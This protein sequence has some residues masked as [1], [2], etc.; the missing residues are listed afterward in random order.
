M[1]L[2]S[3][4]PGCG[5]NRVLIELMGLLVREPLPIVSPN[6]GPLFR[7]IE[8]LRPTILMSEAEALAGNDADA[9]A[10]REILNEGYKR[11]AKVPRC[12]GDDHAVQYFDPYCPK[13]FASIGGL[14]GALLT[15]CI[16]IHMSKR[17]A[18]FPIKGKRQATRERAAKP[19]RERIEAY[20]LQVRQT[21]TRLAEAEPD[22]GYWPDLTN[23][24][25]EVW[26]PLLM[27]ARIAGPQI[28]ERAHAAAC[29][30]AGLNRRIQAQ[31]SRLAKGREVVD[32]L[33]EATGERFRPGDLVEALSESEVW[34]ADLGGCRDAKAKAKAI[35]RY[36]AAYRMPSYKRD[37]LGTGYDRLEAIT[38]I[39]SGLPEPEPEPEKVAMVATVAT[40]PMN[41]RPFD[42]ATTSQPV[43]AS[44]AGLQC[45]AEPVATEAGKSGEWNGNCHAGN[46]HKQWPVATVAT[47]A[48]NP[49][50]QPGLFGGAPPEPV[51]A[52]EEL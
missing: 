28:E 5:K 52:G 18:G 27:H 24:E 49:A 45:K 9:K 13:F 26:G 46:P 16:V 31:D 17:P 21:L 33:R 1:V 36:L 29:L 37:R 34:G 6:V 7:A 11:G 44:P 39:E 19:L 23:R 32:V 41:T 3:A 51:W 10:L 4:G 12:V 48:T 20:A 30:L 43:A 8:D 47:V 15:R 40:S 50:P 42:V 22:E 35:G 2:E 25:G 14:R 38:A